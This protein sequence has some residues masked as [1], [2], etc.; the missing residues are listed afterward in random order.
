MQRLSGLDA[1]F[2]YLETPTMHMH[3]A[4]VAVLDPKS[5]PG[6]YDFERLQHYI[7]RGVRTQPQLQRRLVEVPLKID[8]PV[9]LE[10]PHFDTLHHIRRVSCAAPGGQAE[11]AALVGRIMSTPLD[12]AKPLWEGWVIEGL[13]GGRVALVAKVHHAITD[14]VSGSQILSA[15]F[16]GSPEAPPREPLR[17]HEDDEPVPSEVDLLR[18]A[19]A[20]RIAR[21]KEIVR[22]FK[23]TSNAV[24]ELYERRK[25]PEHQA[26][27][28]VFDSPRTRW[29]G[30][31]S[32]QRSVGFA[33]VPVADVKTIRKAFGVSAN[34]VVLAICAGALRFYLEQRGELPLAPLIAAC[35]I[36]TRVR[37]QSGNRV[38]AMVTSLATHLESPAERL[39]TIR[40]VTR[41][42]KQEHDA[43]GGDLIRSWAELAT[44]GL[45]TTAARLYSKYRLSELHRPMFNLMISNVPGPR[46]PIYLAGAQ[47]AAIYPLG[48]ISEG[49]GLNITVMTYTTHVDFGFITS[50]ALVD[51]IDQLAAL[52]PP[53]TRELLQAAESAQPVESHKQS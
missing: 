32:A 8:H 14:G 23:R 30:P 48:P 35:P 39:R 53:A 10:E 28:S 6:G 17:A 7:D 2:L 13:E 41:N 37:G 31:L 1:S 4:M 46:V 52:V 15:M 36:A 38:S 33:R 42:A 12:R 20:A 26:N 29:N 47:L 45:V 34:E 11:L 24:K 50:P 19:L 40:A 18:D 21:P 9:W 49:A 5:M 22:M 44:P 25:D 51:D 16:S 27:V 3:V 43:L